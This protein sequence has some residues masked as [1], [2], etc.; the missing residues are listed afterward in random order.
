MT[1]DE[2][3]L[4]RCTECGML[5]TRIGWLHAHIEKHRGFFGLQWPWNVADVDELMEMT[6]TIR[7]TEYETDLGEDSEQ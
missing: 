5:S 7:V 6:E 1:N 4:Y 3:E 2:I